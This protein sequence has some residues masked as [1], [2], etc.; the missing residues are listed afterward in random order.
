MGI[1]QRGVGHL[2]ET[3][4]G[5]PHGTQSAES[6]IRVLQIAGRVEFAC[7]QEGILFEHMLAQMNHGVVGST[8]AVGNVSYIVLAVQRVAI[9][10]RLEGVQHLRQ[11]HSVLLSILPGAIGHVFLMETEVATILQIRRN[12]RALRGH[13]LGIKLHALLQQRLSAGQQSSNHRVLNLRGVRRHEIRLPRME[14]VDGIHLLFLLIVHIQLH[15]RIQI[16]LVLQGH[17]QVL[18]R[19]TGQQRVVHHRRLAHLPQRAI[20]PR[21]VLASHRVHTQ[22]NLHGREPTGISLLA[23]VAL[24]LRS[25]DVLVFSIGHHL[26]LVEHQLVVA[27]VASSRTACK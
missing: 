25:A 15:L 11:C 22:G 2:I 16:T 3:D 10:L 17:L 18:T 27:Q 14:H 13:R 6:I 23:H 12:L 20:D 4:V 24:Q 8:T 19:L 9:L 5:I 21:A 1:E 7:P 26:H